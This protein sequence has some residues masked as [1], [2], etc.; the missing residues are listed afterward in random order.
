MK[1]ILTVLSLAMLMSSS[2]ILSME[3][4]NEACLV[5][6][7]A[8]T[9]GTYALKGKGADSFI[10]TPLRRIRGLTGIEFNRRNFIVSIFY[11][12]M[13]FRLNSE[14]S[15]RGL[16]AAQVAFLKK[17]KNVPPL[18][19]RYF[20]PG[21]E[22]PVES[23]TFPLEAIGRIRPAASVVDPTPRP[24]PTIRASLRPEIL[25][26]DEAYRAARRAI[27]LRT[28]ASFFH[29]ASVTGPR[30]KFYIGSRSWNLI[31]LL[32][33]PGVSQVSFNETTKRVTVVYN[34]KTF[35]FAAPGKRFPQKNLLAFHIYTH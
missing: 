4:K 23:V 29:S 1:K 27:G 33:I 12:S 11:S 32:P 31:N 19:E 9:P 3:L 8:I 24:T 25:E 34:S 6:S 30:G 28:R 2:L 14:T 10:L 21:Y 20:T 35:Q 7:G 22:R 16:P 26:S 5:A 18:K 17:L 13:E 15:Y